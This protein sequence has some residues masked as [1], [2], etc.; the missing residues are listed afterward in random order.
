M[1]GSSNPAKS[2]GKKSPGKDKSPG[3]GVKAKSKKQLIFNCDFIDDSDIDCDTDSVN[4]KCRSN[5]DEI[6]VFDS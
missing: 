1:Y 2:P 3:K 4:V 5:V 6:G